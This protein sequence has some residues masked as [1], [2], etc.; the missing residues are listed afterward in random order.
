MVLAMAA[1]IHA[2]PINVALGA[3]VTASGADASGTVPA[4][5]VDG[6]YGTCHQFY[7]TNNG[8]Y[9]LIDLGASYTVNHAYHRAYTQIG[10]NYII[11]DYAILGKLNAADT[12]TQLVNVTGNT[13]LSDDA[14]FT[15]AAVRY[16][17]FDIIYSNWKDPA[18]A[19]FELHEVPEPATLTLLALGGLAILR[20]RH[21]RA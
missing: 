13:S 4:N 14:Y 16:V 9:W 1:P 11:R 20:K 12:F 7:G 21:R 18:V 6:D 17:K 3:S 10:T 15:A 5:L 2:A 8:G 19:E